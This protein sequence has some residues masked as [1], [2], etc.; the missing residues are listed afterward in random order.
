MNTI[1]KAREF[2]Y[3]GM[4][5]HDYNAYRCEV[6]AFKVDEKVR[7]LRHNPVFQIASA[8]FSSVEETVAIYHQQAQSLRNA[9]EDYRKAS[10]QAQRNAMFDNYEAN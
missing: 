8:F 9:A 2:I 7:E 6:E 10:K 3:L 4:V 1:D 5:R